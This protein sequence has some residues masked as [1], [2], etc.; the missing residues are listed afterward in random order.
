MK[1]NHL[2]CIFESKLCT[3][4]AFFHQ[5]TYTNYKILDN[6]KE[7]I[8]KN[9]GHSHNTHVKA[10]MTDWRLFNEDQ[11][12]SEV[13][14][15]FL[16]N[17]AYHNLVFFK[18]KNLKDFKI[19]IKDSWGISYSKG[20]ETVRHAHEGSMYSTCLY[21]SNDTSLYTD[22]KKFSTHKGLLLTCPGW[23]EHWVPKKK[24]DEQTY[25]LV[26]NWDIINE[27]EKN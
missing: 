24:T 4:Q 14:N 20:D 2:D 7:K 1:L 27:W 8:K 9:V 5:M 19:A 26:F 21:F 25:V 23:V 6:L 22:C 13:V 17:I 12:F 15:A 18:N 3:R 10:G 16:K 11:D